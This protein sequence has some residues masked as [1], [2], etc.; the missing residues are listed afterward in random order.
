[1]IVRSYEQYIENE[2]EVCIQKYIPEDMLDDEL[3]TSVDEITEELKEDDAL[4]VAIENLVYRRVK[5]ELRK[6]GIRYE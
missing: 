4:S 6:R 3:W 5:Q 1:M 2:V